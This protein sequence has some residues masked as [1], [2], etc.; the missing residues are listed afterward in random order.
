MR[1]N[2]PCRC[3]ATLHVTYRYIPLQRAMQ[4]ANG[5]ALSGDDAGA[6]FSPR[7]ACSLD[8]RIGELYRSGGSAR[9]E[10]EMQSR[11][12]M[13][14]R[15]EMQ[16][17]MQAQLRQRLDEARC[18]APRGCTSS[19]AVGTSP[20]FSSPAPVSHKKGSKGRSAADGWSPLSSSAGRRSSVPRSASFSRRDEGT[21]GSGSCHSSCCEGTISS[22]MRSFGHARSFKSNESLA[23]PH[24]C[25]SGDSSSASLNRFILEIGQRGVRAECVRV[26][27]A[28]R[29]CARVECAVRGWR[30][31]C[32]GAAVAS[33]RSR[34]M[35][36]EPLQEPPLHAATCRY[37]QSH[38]SAAMGG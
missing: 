32:G 24:L 5:G 14:S 6:A 19:M 1:C 15:A 31:P 12:E 7:L 10:R 34:Y 17:E 18:E 38:Q 4:W 8:D 28:R 25:R 27:C 22:A 11:E 37:M 3:T 33:E 35:L 9:G 23:S 16:V 21:R 30:Q 13:Q 36:Q 2:S 20:A 26:A 29:V